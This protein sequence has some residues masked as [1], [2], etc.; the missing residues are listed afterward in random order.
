[1]LST[2]ILLLFGLI[3]LAVAVG[4]AFFVYIYWFKVQRPV[5]RLDRDA[6]LPGLNRPVRIQR[7]KHAI[8]H[9]FAA[10]ADDL[11][12]AQGYAHAQERFWQMEQSRRV[13]HGT[14]AELFGEPALEADRFSRII[15]F[16]R[17]AAAE[18]EATDAETGH[19]LD[20]YAQ[21][22]NAFLDAHPGRIAAELNLL[23]TSPAP[24]SPLDSIAVGK[25]IAWGLSIN[26]ESELTRLRLLQRLGPNRAA[27]L[28]PDYPSSTPLVL[29]CVGE[30]EMPRLLHTAGL[31]LNQY[32]LL[33]QWLGGAGEGQGSN[34]WVVAPK[35]S[36]TRRA[37]LCNDPHLVLKM[38]GIWFE[39]RLQSPDMNVS[40]VSFPGIPGVIIGHND[41]IA[42]GMTNA[43]VDVQDLYL[44]KP[45]PD[46]P[47]HFAHA[48]GWEEATVLEE[49]I[50]VRRQADRVERVLITRHGPII[51]ELLRGDG[52]E[53]GP[54]PYPLALR[55][56]GHE[57]GNT[58]RAI[59]NL[60]RASDF[61]DFDAALADWGAPPQNVTYADVRGNIGY[62]L[63][64]T[65]PGRKHNP[66]LVPAPGWTGKHEWEEA[67]PH[68][69]W[70]RIYNPDSGLIVT[71]NQ[72]IVGDD[73]PHFL[74]VEFFPGWRAA[75]IEALL[76]KKERLTVREME[77]IQLDTG[78]QFAERLAPWIALLNSDDPWEN[79]ALQA[80]RNWN[81]R[82]DTD[83]EA[84][85]VFHY[86]LLHLQ[87]LVFGDKL[88]QA[89]D[90]YLGLSQNPLFPLNGFMS[91]A[92]SR[93]LEILDEHEASAWYLDVKTDRSRTR[94][95]VLQEALTRAVRTIRA[96][97][98]DSTRKWDWGRSHQIR[99]VHPMGSVRL[100]RGFF[101]RGPFPIGGDG[102]TLNQTRHAPHLPLGLVQITPS[103]RQIYEVGVWDQ[104]STVTTS[105]QS[106]H[107]FSEHYDDQITL[108]RE[109]VYHAMPWTQ[110]AVDAATVYSMT[111]MPEPASKGVTADT[112]S[113]SSQSPA[114]T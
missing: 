86:T 19:V 75:R 60:N 31:L 55:W 83:S 84:A 73:F 82:M 97:V 41:Q 64:G 1:M 95:E 94:E 40:G 36:L 67:I 11:F 47:T 18:L 27:E 66:G 63:A 51:S 8:P 112:R 39:N 10:D 13:A 37:L 17:A 7:D 103:Y 22:V 56:T 102:T 32:D 70:P 99:Y 65:M 26:W 57:P 23:R 53:P 113:E 80:I 20:C 34:S 30:A 48:D 98:G 104:A 96:Q 42:W 6:R 87:D 33:R 77:R 15:G 4:G 61:D 28:E 49:T 93:L 46:N 44:E 38:P 21:G 3:V 5:P 108:F 89:R 59:L 12:R 110:D 90:G 109:G 105:G 74:G 45:D 71:A 25:V 35:R 92:E 16:R 68:A 101:N 85:L 2:L 43:M 52:D 106:G 79:A 24:W 29:E 14:L 72:K 58:L 114:A 81:Y 91:R 54:V 100:L 107:P 78:S 62:L 88:G 9:L 76:G 111:L 50:S 69:E